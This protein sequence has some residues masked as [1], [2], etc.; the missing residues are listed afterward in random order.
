M[1]YD[2]R[3]PSFRDMI[4]VNWPWILAGCVYV[5]GTLIIIWKLCTT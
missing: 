4:A 5:I 3:K 2:D 1:I